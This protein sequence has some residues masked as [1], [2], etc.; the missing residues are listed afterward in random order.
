MLTRRRA[1]GSGGRLGARER[2]L[3]RSRRVAACALAL[4]AATAAAPVGPLASPAAAAAP[5]FGVTVDSISQPQAITAALA[6][7]PRRATT[8]V[9]FDVRE[10][11][12][13]YARAVQAI[14]G[15]SGVMG[16]LLDSSDET[17]ISSEALQARTREYL[18][19]LGSAVDIWEIGNEV[20][21]NWTGEYA[22]VSQKL[23][24]A[25]EAVS[26]TGA[27]TAL[28]LYANKVRQAGITTE[29]MEIVSGAEAMRAQ[30]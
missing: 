17:S 27:Q 9:Y 29:L 19:A 4:A 6:A 21:G 1:P 20:N 8:R 18:G 3:A 7:L 5:L 12:S 30:G 11:A 10:P 15:V 22:V 16:E 23:T 24:A 28:T 13:Y 2:R 26:A 25:F 14:H